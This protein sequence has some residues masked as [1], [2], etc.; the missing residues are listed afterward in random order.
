M[1]SMLYIQDIPSVT[2]ID[3]IHYKLAIIN[4]LS[5]A[6]YKL[7]VFHSWMF[8]FN[9]VIQYD[10]FQKGEKDIYIYATALLSV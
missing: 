5:L 8:M 10:I 7:N 9:I 2:A 3:A 6:N 4:Y 1:G